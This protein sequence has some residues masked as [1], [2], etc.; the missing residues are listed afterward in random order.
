MVTLG[1]V[2]K[3]GRALLEGA[4]DLHVHPSPSIRNRSTDAWGVA[5]AG[6]RY[7][8]LG[9]LFKD[10]DRA[11]I[12]DCHYVNRRA[13]TRFEAYASICLNDTVGGLNPSAVETAARLGARAVFLPTNS[14]ANDGRV[15]RQGPGSSNARLDTVGEAP[16]RWATSLSILDSSGELTEE[17]TAVIEA[18]VDAKITLC[19]GHLGEVEITALL[20]ALADRELQVLVTHAPSFTGASVGSL[21]RWADLGALLELVYVFSCS[22]ISLPSNLRRSVQ[23]DA[24]LIETIGAEHF[25][26]STDLGQAA[27]PPP[28]EGLAIFISGLLSEGIS[29]SD[30]RLMVRQNPWR[31]IGESE[32]EEG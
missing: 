4:I 21:R 28:P 3:K 5:E 10:H 26:L 25:V 9:A 1:N 30:I 22:S 24:S 31:L 32:G 14:A 17:A 20:E 18:C 16:R 27:A 23:M 7:G 12:A 29:E 15:W 11:T 19:T 13:Q 2:S 8:M 6:E